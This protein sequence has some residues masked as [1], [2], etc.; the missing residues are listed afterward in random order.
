VDWHQKPP[1][2]VRSV[3]HA[4]HRAEVDRENLAQS[5][6]VLSMDWDCV[7]LADEVKRLR[8]GRA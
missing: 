3:E 4:M 2:Y 6:D 7:I 5:T 8:N 1:P